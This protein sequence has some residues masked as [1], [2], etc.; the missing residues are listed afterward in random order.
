MRHKYISLLILGI[1]FFSFTACRKKSVLL[2]ERE[3]KIIK[4]GN[5]VT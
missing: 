5:V 1:C 4:N 3:I 2:K